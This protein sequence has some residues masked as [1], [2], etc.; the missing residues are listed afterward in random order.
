M[1]G[2]WVVRRGQLTIDGGVCVLGDEAG[3]MEQHRPI[4]RTAHGLVVPT[5]LPP[6]VF[7][8]S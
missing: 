7:A 5:P 1:Y 3:N 2:T 8:S 6:S 4:A